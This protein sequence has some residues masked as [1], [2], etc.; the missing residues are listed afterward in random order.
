MAGYGT[1]LLV[2]QSTRPRVLALHRHFLRLARDWNPATGTLQ[3][4]M[5]EVGYICQQASTLFRQNAAITDEELIKAHIREAES[6]IELAKHY[7][8]PYRRLAN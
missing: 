1:S 6:R 8:T 5:A 2:I 3:D 7:G 4:T